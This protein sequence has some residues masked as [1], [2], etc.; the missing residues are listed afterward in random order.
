[1]NTR[2]FHTPYSVTD[3]RNKAFAYEEKYETLTQQSDKTDADINIIM[4]RFGATGQLPQRIEP[5]Q[6][7]DFTNAPDFRAAQEIL[8]EA[9]EAFGNVD[10]QIRKKFNNDPAEFFAFVNNP[11]NLDEMRKMG[12]ANPAPEPEESEVNIYTRQPL[13]R[14]DDDGEYTESPTET[15]NGRSTRTDADPRRREDEPAPRP[16]GR[17]GEGR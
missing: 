7:A 3:E 1:M 5:G 9:R 4:A 14:Y 10:A 17:P 11:D 2:K 13:T 15:R 12:L 16:R 6:Y 8:L